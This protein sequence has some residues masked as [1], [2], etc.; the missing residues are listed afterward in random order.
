MGAHLPTKTE[1]GFQA[2]NHSLSLSQNIFLARG[3]LL[4][5]CGK[6]YKKNNFTYI[7]FDKFKHLK[8]I[9]VWSQQLMQKDYLTT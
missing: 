9:I 5:S 8:Y 1:W 7:K 2:K 4:T 3:G 6:L